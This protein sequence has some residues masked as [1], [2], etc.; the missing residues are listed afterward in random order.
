[1][2]LF[3]LIAIICVPSFGC[4]DL[5]KPH[6]EIKGLE[7]CKIEAQKELENIKQHYMEKKIPLKRIRIYCKEL[8]QK[9][10]VS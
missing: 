10:Q 6:P 1:M 5:V 7:Q 8:P 3:Y 9:W 2:K 4:F